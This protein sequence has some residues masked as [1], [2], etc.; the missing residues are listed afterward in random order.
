MSRELQLGQCA[1]LCLV[2][3]WPGPWAVV[4]SPNPA[5]VEI[6][7][8]PH[9]RAPDRAWL[10]VPPGQQVHFPSEST[11]IIALHVQGE[12]V[13]RVAYMDNRSKP[14]VSYKNIRAMN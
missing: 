2:D 3:L 10:R 14:F 6:S 1:R 7:R 13:D 12:L 11:F 4:C 8:L 5:Q 9:G